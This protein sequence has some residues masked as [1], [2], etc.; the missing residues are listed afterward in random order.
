MRIKDC[1]W[2]ICLGIC[3]VLCAGSLAHAQGL[4]GG[5]GGFQSETYWAVGYATNAPQQLMGFSTLLFGPRLKGWGIYADVKKGLSTPEDEKGYS[6]TLTPAEARGFEDLLIKERSAWRSANVAAVR[7]LSPA[8]AVYLGGGYSRESAYQRY[9]DAGQERGYLGY[10][11]VA[12]AARSGGHLNLLAGAWFRATSRILFQ[13][14][15][16]M[17]PGGFTAGAAY[18]FPIRR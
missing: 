10:Y 14:G 9:L 4:E 1:W 18:V 7:V 12:D 2:S 5:G 3:G 6:S 17:A 11:W 8:L 15:G 16:E 13:F